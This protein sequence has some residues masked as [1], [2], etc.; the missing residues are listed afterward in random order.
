MSSK[1]K[2]TPIKI[3]HDHLI[4]ESS[5]PEVKRARYSAYQLASSPTSSLP[6]PSTSPFS[7]QARPLS[8]ASISPSS[9]TTSSS[10]EEELSALSAF[11]HNNRQLDWRR[12]M[13]QKTG[14]SCLDQLMPEAEGSVAQKQAKINMMIQELQRMHNSLAE[15]T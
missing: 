8:R 11:G 7:T 15:V 2:N 5:P 10:R 9:V 1:R 6:S 14:D 13:A 4:H 12:T 3:S